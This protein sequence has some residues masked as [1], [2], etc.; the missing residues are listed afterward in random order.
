MEEIP[1]KM[2]DY[3]NKV[4]ILKNDFM[5]NKDR[6]KAI[7][8]LK[9]MRIIH[10]LAIYQNNLY[11]KNLNESNLTVDEL[12][13]LSTQ[14]SLLYVIHNNIRSC[15]KMLYDKKFKSIK[16]E[17]SFNNA[18]DQ[19]TTEYINNLTTTEANNLFSNENQKG[20]EDKNEMDV[21]KPTIINYWADWCGYSKKFLPKW[22]KF[23][24]EAKEK[25][26]NLQVLDLNVKNDE[27]LNNMAKKAGVS[28]YPTLVLYKDGNKKYSI[29]SNMNTD[30]IIKF[31]DKK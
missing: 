21:K 26:P 15:E 31:I 12:L 28:G 5:Q 16:S 7:E 10:G 6:N 11:I 29:A 8:I 19:N 24:I 13:N 20:G 17:N 23:K 14:S 30:D 27:E 1:R 25:Y 2:N 9:E 18:K 4:S 22:E 3:I